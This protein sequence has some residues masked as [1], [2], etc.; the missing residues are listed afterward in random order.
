MKLTS[1]LFLALA[2]PAS[3]LVMPGAA[4]AQAVVV[5]ASATRAVPLVMIDKKKPNMKGASYAARQRDAVGG[6]AGSISTLVGDS[7]DTVTK[8][9]SGINLAYVAVWALVSAKL[10]GLF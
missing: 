5:V 4:R 7:V 9:G 1:F 6:G 10:F 8:L 3:A 2:L